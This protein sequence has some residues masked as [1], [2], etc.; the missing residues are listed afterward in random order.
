MLNIKDLKELS[1]KRKPEWNN[2]LKKNRKKL[3]KMDKTIAAIHEEV[4]AEIDCLQCGNCCRSLGPRILS[5][6]ADLLAKTLRMKPGDFADKYLRKDEDDDLVFKT[7]PCPFLGQDNY[8]AVYES[9]P[10]A[11]REYPHTDRKK[12]YQ[13]YQLSVKNAETCPI[14]FEVLERIVKL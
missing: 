11:C 14:V 10:K 6:D 1:S 13:I 5:A 8:C 7:M 12:F 4:S 2:W 9:R 3:E